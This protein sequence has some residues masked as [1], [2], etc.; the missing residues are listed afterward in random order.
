MFIYDEVSVYIIVAMSLFIQ[1]FLYKAYLEQNLGTQVYYLF[2][3][4]VA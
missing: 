1:W 4:F 2:K 3:I